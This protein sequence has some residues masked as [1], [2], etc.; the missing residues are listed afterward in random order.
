MCCLAIRLF[1]RFN[2]KYK[3]MDMMDDWVIAFTGVWVIRFNLF[4]N[5]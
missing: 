2:I 3:W 1:S 4:P 5:I